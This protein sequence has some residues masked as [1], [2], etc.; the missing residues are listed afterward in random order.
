MS[1][2]CNSNIILNMTN[3]NRT[4]KVSQNIDNFITTIFLGIVSRSFSAQFMRCN[5]DLIKINI[6]YVSQRGS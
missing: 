2:M 4:S 3:S 6:N 5:G 1:Q